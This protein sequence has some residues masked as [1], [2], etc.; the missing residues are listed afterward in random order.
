MALSEKGFLVPAHSAGREVES[1]RRLV[2]RFNGK[3]LQRSEFVVEPVF[4]YIS[5]NDSFLG[6]KSGN[7]PTLFTVASPSYCLS[8]SRS[9]SHR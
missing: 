1:Y 9:M 3:S 8:N 7:F 2:N 5:R 4:A 6:V